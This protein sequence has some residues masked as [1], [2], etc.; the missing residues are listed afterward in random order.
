MELFFKNKQLCFCNR[1]M[2]LLG[3]ASFYKCGYSLIFKLL[4]FCIFHGQCFLLCHA[5]ALSLPQE[6]G[7]PCHD[8]LSLSWQLQFQLSLEHLQDFVALCYSRVSS[9]C[10]HVLLLMC[11]HRILC[12][13]GSRG[14]LPQHISCSPQ[15]TFWVPNPFLSRVGGV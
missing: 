13:P 8:T 9:K 3:E 15:A 5:E 12:E 7:C 2:F 10:I 14:A 11:G 4:Q 1:N 6:A